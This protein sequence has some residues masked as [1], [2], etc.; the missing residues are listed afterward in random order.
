MS[1]M[2]LPGKHPGPGV[3][4]YQSPPEARRF[5]LR[6][7]T[8]NIIRRCPVCGE[9]VAGV[10]SRTDKARKAVDRAMLVHI[11]GVHGDEY[12]KQF[13]QE[14]KQDESKK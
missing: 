1:A 3:M 2:R 14:M 9:I 7:E 4:D 8:V 11:A 13:L 6:S 10:D 12:H 5:A